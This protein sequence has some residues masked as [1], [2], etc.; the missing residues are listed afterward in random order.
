MQKWMELHRGAQ[1]EIIHLELKIRPLDVSIVPDGML[2]L[3]AEQDAFEKLTGFN[4]LKC[5]LL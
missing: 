1:L 2:R 3:G 4:N 5:H